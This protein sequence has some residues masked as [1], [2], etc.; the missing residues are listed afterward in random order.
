M[1]KTILLIDDHEM[2]REF[3]SIYLRKNNVVITMDSALEAV[4]WLE[5]GNYA[6]AIIADLDMPIMN[7][8]EF[9]ER[10]RQNRFFKDIP[11]AVISS[12]YKSTDRIKCYQL[13][14]DAYITKPFNPKELEIQLIHLMNNVVRV[15]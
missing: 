13:G 9:I 5:E 11:I 2:M 10:V 3:L 14:A 8:F 7:G 15:A 4:S 1:K 6:D 12:H